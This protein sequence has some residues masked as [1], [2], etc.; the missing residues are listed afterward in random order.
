MILSESKRDDLLLPYVEML[1]AKGIN[2]S[3]GQLKSY[4]LK[5]LTNEA[6][7][8]N[9]SLGSNFYLAGAIRYYFNGDLTINKDLDVYNDGQTT[10][11]V[12]NEDA[13]QKLNALIPRI[14]LN[15]FLSDFMDD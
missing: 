10:N 4:M 7:M 15:L 14:H 13:C 6:R 1:K 11:D 2:C 3:L 12:W 8:R 9:L 5:K